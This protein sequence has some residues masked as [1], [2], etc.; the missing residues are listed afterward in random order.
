MASSSSRQ[1]RRSSKRAMLSRAGS[2]VDWGGYVFAYAERRA[3]EKSRQNLMSLDIRGELLSPV[4][5]RSA[6]RW[7]QT[8]LRRTRVCS[9]SA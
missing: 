8:Q 5:A 3:G 1:R 4:R 2:V 6:K 9:M 7:R